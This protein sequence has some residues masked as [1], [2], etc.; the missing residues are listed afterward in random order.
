MRTRNVTAIFV[1]ILALTLLASAPAQ[2]YDKTELKCRGT[3]VKGFAKANATAEKVLIGCHAGKAKGKVAA[4]VDCN[5]ISAADNKGK[6]AKAAGKVTSGVTKKCPAS[7]DADLL[8]NY[9]GCPEPCGT[10]TGV[11]AAIDSYAEMG[12][13]MACLASSM[14]EDNVEA[15]LGSPSGLDKGQGKCHAAIGKGYTK[16]VATAAKERTKCQA[17][18]DK[19]GNHDTS[20]CATYDG[21]GKIGK[22][23]AKAVKGVDKKCTADHLAAID[24]CSSASTSALKTC[25][26]SQ[27]TGAGEDLYDT[28]YSLDALV[29]PVGVRTEVVSGA[30]TATILDAGWAGMGHNVSITGAYGYT[31]SV[32]CPNEVPPCGTCTITGIDPAASTDL[33]RCKSDPTQ[34]CTNLFGNDA[35][36]PDGGACIAYLGPPLPL[37]SGGNPV[38][39]LNRM[40][41]DLT[42]T[43]NAE[44]GEG[45]VA[46]D[47][48]SQTHLGEDL[49]QPCPLCVDGTCDLGPQAGEACVVHGL[50]PTF[51]PSWSR[52]PSLDCPPSS[53]KNISGEGLKIDLPLSTG[54]SSLG[55]DNACDSPVNMY[56]CAC[57][58]CSGDSQMPCRNDAECAAINAGTCTSFGVGTQRYPNGCSGGGVPEPLACSAIDAEGILG[59]CTYGPDNRFCDGEL[60]ANGDGYISCNTDADC[61]AVDEV[62]GTGESGACGNCTMLARRKCFLDPIKALGVPD[63]E[64]PVLGGTFCIPPVANTAIN[65][66]AGLPGAGRVMVQMEATRIY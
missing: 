35:V 65:G 31:V 2:A 59:E 43:A 5:D 27:A 22:A 57:G 6:F 50:H 53:L 49:T 39:V 9:L 55:F 20:G 12:Q 13:C 45:S 30:G 18:Q 16:L 33:V 47:M 58:T 14:A 44:T 41:S 63:L 8:D 60:R 62:C 51:G 26:A 37:S 10:S 40:V 1:G 64:T 24:S 21:K 19:T 48:R 4:G 61:I 7:M 3:I 32:D 46:P 42:G 11:G 66:A 15:L 36:C 38:C 23:L 29:C 25:L 56:Q 52:G 54:E 17:G 34:L 28:A